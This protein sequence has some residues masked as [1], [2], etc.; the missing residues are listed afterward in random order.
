MFCLKKIVLYIKI[1]MIK[2]FLFLSSNLKKKKIVHCFAFFY[3][4]TYSFMHN[5]HERTS[6]CYYAEGKSESI[7]IQQK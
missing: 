4:I 2:M 3:S 1:A 7:L 6:F 5:C